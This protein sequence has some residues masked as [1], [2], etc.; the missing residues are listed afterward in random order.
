[1]QATV[2]NGQA[3]TVRAKTNEDGETLGEMLANCSERT[4]YFFHPYPLTHQSGLKVGADE[5]I[6]CSIAEAADGKAVG[7][8]WIGREGDVPTLGICVRDGWQGVGV[9]RTLMA[10]ITAEAKRLRKKGLQ[11]TVM[12]DNANAIALYQ[13][14]GFIIDGDASDRVGPSYHMTLRFE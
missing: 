4:Y 7:Y 3:I 1:M 13:S 11:L 2:K 5:N 12:K 14:F 10:R 9:G 8:V 6:I